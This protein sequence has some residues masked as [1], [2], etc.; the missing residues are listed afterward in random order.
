MLIPE[1]IIGFSIGMAAA[2]YL[3]QYIFTHIDAHDK[4]CRNILS[5]TVHLTDT[6]SIDWGSLLEKVYKIFLLRDPSNIKSYLESPLQLDQLSN[7]H[8]LFQRKEI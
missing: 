5:E 3:T 4:E 8:T 7:I 1:N 6:Y 2:Y